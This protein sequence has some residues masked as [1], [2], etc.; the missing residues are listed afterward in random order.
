MFVWVEL[1]PGADA[2]ALL[3]NAVEQGVAFV[4][5]AP[6]FAEEER[7]NSLRLSFATLSPSQISEA[8][9]RLQAALNSRPGGSG[10]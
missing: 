6:F 7:R 1:P 8:L 4:P 10:V 2:L 3:P 9:R 5:G